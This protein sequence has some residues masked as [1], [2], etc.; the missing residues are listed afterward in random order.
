MMEFSLW[1]S[2]TLFNTTMPAKFATIMMIFIIPEFQL[3]QELM[4]KSTTELNCPKLIFTTSCYH[5]TQLDI[6]RMKSRTTTVT[7][8]R[9]YALLTLTRL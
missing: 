2:K 4:K 9:R 3:R 7:R 5:N 6:C 8:D 1:L